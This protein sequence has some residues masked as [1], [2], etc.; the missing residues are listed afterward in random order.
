[1]SKFKNSE[2]QNHFQNIMN[3]NLK[4]NENTSNGEIEPEWDVIKW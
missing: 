1:M 3:R 2:T 4:E